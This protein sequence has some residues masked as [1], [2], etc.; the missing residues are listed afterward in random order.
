VA[1]A[2]AFVTARTAERGMA[3]LTARA[4]RDA[5]PLETLLAG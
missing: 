1:A 3:A 5:T 4:A 2:V